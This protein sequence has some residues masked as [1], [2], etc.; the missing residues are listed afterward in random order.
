[1]IKT[2]SPADYPSDINRDSTGKMNKEMSFGSL[3]GR[4]EFGKRKY[5]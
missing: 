3:M 1:V 4:S 5:G 2:Y